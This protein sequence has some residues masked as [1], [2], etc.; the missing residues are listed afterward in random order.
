MKLKSLRQRV[1]GSFIISAI[2]MSTVFGGVVYGFLHG[3]ED[4]IIMN[5]LEEEYRSFSEAYVNSVSAPLPQ[6][7]IL[8]GEIHNQ[9]REDLGLDRGIH[10]IG[11]RHI[12]VREMSDGNF[13]YLFHDDERIEPLNDFF[14]TQIILSALFGV[15]LANFLLGLS[16]S[17]RLLAPLLS[18]TAKV[19]QAFPDVIRFKP[20][21]L[22]SFSTELKVLARG[23]QDATDRVDAFIERERRFTSEASHELRTPVTVIKGASTILQRNC[24]SEDPKCQ[25]AWRRMDRSVKDMEAIIQ[26]FLFL[27]RQGSSEIEATDIELNQLVE[28]IVSTN[29]YLIEDKP[30]TYRLETLEESSVCLVEPIL[31]IVIGNLVRNAFQYTQN[32]VVDLDLRGTFLRISNPSPGSS[33]NTPLRSQFGIGLTIVEDL[34]S[35]YGWE[36]DLISDGRT[37]TASLN[38]KA[39]IDQRQP[40]KEIP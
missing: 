17:N 34:C 25:A 21:E 9:L 13:L 6:S 11:D 15:V 22:N 10:E 39:Q 2:V 28:E 36:W 5:Y 8:K 24:L 29:A 19:K 30:V 40:A 7:S 20:E 18:M 27:A 16:I 37:V 14:L 23:L 31:K 3:L 12:L 38:L 4:R 26:T 32:G 1:V 35:A 33:A